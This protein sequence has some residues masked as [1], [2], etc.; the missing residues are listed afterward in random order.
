MSHVALYDSHTFLGS[1]QNLDP[2]QRLQTWFPGCCAHSKQPVQNKHKRTAVTLLMHLNEN[3]ITSTYLIHFIPCG[4]QVLFDNM[5]LKCNL[6]YVNLDIG[7]TLAL[8]HATHQVVLSNQILSLQQVNPQ[9][10]L[11]VKLK[12]YKIRKKAYST[13]Y[14][15]CW[16]VLCFRKCAVCSENVYKR[17]I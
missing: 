13:L 5:T 6:S 10:P 1:R 17:W 16:L 9:Q 7:V 12:C 3:N 4:V 8:H 11:Q 2:Y 14:A 15:V